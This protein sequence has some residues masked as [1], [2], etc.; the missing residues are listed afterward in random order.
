MSPFHVGHG[1][2]REEEEAKKYDTFLSITKSDIILQNIW[3]GL[4]RFL[5]QQNWPKP[6]FSGVQS[7]PEVQC[8]MQMNSE[9]FCQMNSEIFIVLLSFL[10]VV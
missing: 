3:V 8:T 6:F 5:H 4:W 9:I 2:I 7:D 10:T 1:E